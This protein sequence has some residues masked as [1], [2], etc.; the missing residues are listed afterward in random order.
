V[1]GSNITR[2]VGPATTTAAGTGVGDAI[3]Y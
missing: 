3:D 1:T 2:A